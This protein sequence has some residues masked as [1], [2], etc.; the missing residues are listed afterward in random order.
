MIKP[1]HTKLIWVSSGQ[2]Y[3]IKV[4]KGFWKKGYSANR[5]SNLRQFGRLWQP[6]KVGQLFPSA[7]IF[8]F[9]LPSNI[10]PSQHIV[11]VEDTT[12]IPTEIKN[13]QYF[14]PLGKH[15]WKMGWGWG[16]GRNAW[17]DGLGHY[18]EKNCPISNGR[19]LLFVIFCVSIS[20]LYLYL[21]LAC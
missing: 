20:Y 14:Y 6:G 16:E 8:P 7:T 18:L 13:I 21:Y 10:S 3:V 19:L 15:H 9:L 1:Q 2:L 5:N 11:N 4:K 17:K 12:N